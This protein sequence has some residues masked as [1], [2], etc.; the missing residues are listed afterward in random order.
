MSETI[1]ILLDYDGRF[2]SEWDKKE[3]NLEKF[4]KCLGRQGAQVVPV[5][6]CDIDFSSMDFKDKIIL[7]SSAEAKYYK[8]YV[9]DILLGIIHQGGILIP[10]YYLFRAHHNKAFQEV[11][12]EIFNFGNLKGRAYGALVEFINR[13]QN[14]NWPKVIKSSDDAGGKNVFLAKNLNSAL[15]IAKKLSNSHDSILKRWFLQS[16]AIVAAKLGIRNKERIYRNNTKKFIAQEY[17]PDLRDDWKILVFAD[18]YYALNRKVRKRDF[19]ASGSGKFSYAHCPP[20]L[21]DFAKDIFS[22][23]DTPYAAF[24]IAFDGK[25]YYLL[26]FQA[27][28]FGLYTVLNADSYYVKEDEVWTKKPKELSIEE[29]ISDSILKFIKR[30]IAAPFISS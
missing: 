14:L 11:Y 16:R 19:R 23:L 30:G 6:F 5:R 12:K 24:D 28:F 8:D 3:F 1:Y 10:N 9:E 29:E 21:L 25:E 20:G 22:K 27:V 18:R 4:I 26:E 2:Y 13:L 15:R 7:Y 17:V